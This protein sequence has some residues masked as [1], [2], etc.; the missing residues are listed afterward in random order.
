[1]TQEPRCPIAGMVAFEREFL[2]AC[3][4]EAHLRALREH[5]P[6][7]P[8]VRSGRDYPWHVLHGVCWDGED[9]RA[10]PVF[11]VAVPL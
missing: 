4:R 5:Q 1:M 8:C 7:V 6:P 10:S 3:H 11:R 2:G 9:P